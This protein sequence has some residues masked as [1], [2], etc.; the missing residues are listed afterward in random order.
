MVNKV[1]S[2]IYKAVPVATVSISKYSWCSFTRLQLPCLP[3]FLPLH[4][5]LPQHAFPRSPALLH[6]LHLFPMCIILL[7]RRGRNDGH[8]HGRALELARDGEPRPALRTQ[9]PHVRR[10]GLADVGSLGL[11]ERPQRGRRAGVGHGRGLQVHG[12]GRRAQERRCGRGRQR[13]GRRR[14]RRWAVVEG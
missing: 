12:R 14:R 13:V 10:R 11:G 4:P 5:H 3:K 7:P 8:E 9:P 1:S 6:L 2:K